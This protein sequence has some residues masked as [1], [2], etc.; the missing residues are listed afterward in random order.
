MGKFLQFLFG[1]SF[2]FWAH[3]KLLENSCQEYDISNISTTVPGN[4]DFVKWFQYEI[5]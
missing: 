1:E 3:E 4:E 2:Q 5:Q